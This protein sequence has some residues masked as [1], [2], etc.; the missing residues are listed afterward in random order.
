MFYSGHERLH[1]MVFQAI[2]TPDGLISSLFGP[3]TSRTNDLGM[4][5]ASRVP[6]RLHR[7]MP[8]S[9]K[10]LYLDGDPAYHYSYGVICSFGLRKQLSRRK[11]RFNK[12]LSAHRIAVEHSF[13]QIFR[14]WTSLPFE[15]GL[16]IGNQ[17]VTAFPLVTALLSNCHTCLDGGNQTSIK[18]QLEPLTLA[19]YLGLCVSDL[20]GII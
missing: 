20:A 16:K 17:A 19:E 13:G 10:M 1:R 12:E 8:A 14:Q 11:R 18:Y 6:H 3:F 15:Q 4:F 7:M 9:N 2:T 5:N